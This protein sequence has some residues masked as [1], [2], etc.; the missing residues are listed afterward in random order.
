MSVKLYCIP[1]FA[2]CVLALLMGCGSSQGAYPVTVTQ[3]AP[4]KGNRAGTATRSVWEQPPPVQTPRKDS[5]DIEGRMRALGDSLRLALLALPPAGEGDPI[6]AALL[7][8]PSPAEKQQ[9]EAAIATVRPY[10]NLIAGEGGAQE[11]AQSL[12]RFRSSGRL[13]DLEQ[14]A[15]HLESHL[16]KYPGDS[17]ARIALARVYRI[18][19][20]LSNDQGLNE[21]AIDHLLRLLWLD[22][23]DVNAWIELAQTLES[24][25]RWA[26]AG[27]AWEMG[28]RALISAAQDSPENRAQGLR[29]YIRA[30]RA[31]A[32]GTIFSRALLSIME[33][34]KLI[35]TSEDSTIVADERTWLLWNAPDIESR[36]EFDNIV[37]VFSETN[38]NPPDDVLTRLD[39][40][41]NRAMTLRARAETAELLAI[42]LY[43]RGE[44][45]KAIQK[46][47]P[48][49]VEAAK[50]PE[51]ALDDDMRRIIT[52]YINMAIDLAAEMVKARN[53][54]GAVALLLE[55][56]ELRVV[57]ESQTA[58]L[59]AAIILRPA[60]ERALDVLNKINPD[61]LQD[62]RRYYITKVEILRALG[63]FDEARRIYESI[64]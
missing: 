43:N 39:E 24:I 20:R 28:A 50:L 23:S 34:E 5:I 57:P 47:R 40:L 7:H 14:A 59:N 54:E 25:S 35:S 19:A 30:A 62:P 42:A 56:G 60:P 1:I 21:R 41:H 27:Y 61:L 12:A 16:A 31:Y 52:N 49:A 22:R 3:R 45:E 38:N 6:L 53:R 37:R 29:M 51:S 63:R 8:E 33:A 36:I 2:A 64:N 13:E 17:E 9:V 4:E 48:V 44:K 10:L 32:R 18:A 55:A 46:L 15:R 11:A 26:S 58:L